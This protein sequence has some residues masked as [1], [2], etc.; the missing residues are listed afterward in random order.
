MEGRLD[1]YAT[2]ISPR[3]TDA[4]PLG[5]IA[6]LARRAERHGIDG[7]LIFYDHH[8]LDPWMVAAAILQHTELIT[9]LVAL[10]P[11]ALPPLTAAKMIHSLTALH[12]RRIDLNLITGATP[13]ELDQVLDGLDHEARYAR[14]VEF[15]RI[16]RSLLTSDEPLTYRG[17]YYAYQ[18]L[19]AHCRV[20]AVQQPRVFVAGSSAASRRAADEVADV[21]VTHPEPVSAFVET[22]LPGGGRA[23]ETAVRVGMVARPSSEEAWAAARSLYLA[24]RLSDIRVAMRRKSGSEWSQRLADLTAEGELFD[25]VYWTGAYRSGAGV[26]LLVGGYDEVAA[27]LRRYREAGVTTVMLGGRLRTEED[28][29]HAAVVVSRLRE[30][31]G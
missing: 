15:C 14:A 4:D 28:F 9:P 26:P 23:T 2:A 11:Y 21:A 20:E 25:G 18:L 30:G 19:R 3:P 8:S 10:Q 22:F 24:D 13:T 16:V 1:V 7:L 6:G 17:R 27:Y 12:G 5:R 29:H 31:D